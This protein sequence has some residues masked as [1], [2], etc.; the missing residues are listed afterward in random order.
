MAF[1]AFIITAKRDSAAFAAGAV[2]TARHTDVESTAISAVIVATAH[3]E[4]F[5]YLSFSWDAS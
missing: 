2:G 3:L 4:A 1:A 5:I